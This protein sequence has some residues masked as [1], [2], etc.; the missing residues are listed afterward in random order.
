MGQTDNGNWTDVKVKNLH[1]CRIRSNRSSVCYLFLRPLAWGI[2]QILFNSALKTLH[3]GKKVA[4]YSE[5]RCNQE[6]RSITA[7][8]VFQISRSSVLSL[9]SVSA[10]RNVT[11]HKLSEFHRVKRLI[12]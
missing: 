3:F 8:T 7:H 5:W 1:N 11:S 10:S 2:I 4:F 6:W 12:S 9:A